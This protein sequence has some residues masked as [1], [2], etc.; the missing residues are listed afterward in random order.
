MEIS[1]LNTEFEPV[2]IVDVY[3]SIIWTKRYYKPGDFE[4]YIPAN[5]DILPYLK[6]DYYVKRDD[7]ETVMIIEKIEI[8]T[9]AENGDYFIITGR[10]LESILNRRIVWEQTNLNGNVVDQVYKVLENNIGSSALSYRKLAN[11][12]CKTPKLNVSDTIT[13]QATGDDLE[14]LLTEICTQYGL[15]W[16]IT[17]DEN[18]NFVFEMYKG[19]NSNAYFSPEFDNLITSDYSGDKSNYRNVAK[20][21]GEGEG[22]A[23]TS[24]VVGN[25]VGINRRELYVDA[26]DV[27]SNE[28][29]ITADDYKLLL[30]AR[31]KE[32]LQEQVFVKSFDGEVEP[33][34]TFKYREDYN[35]GDIVTVTNQYGITATPR[36]I[37]IIENWD[38]T[39]YKV[40]P[41][42]EEWEV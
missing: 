13:M 10:S 42:F 37:E 18:N 8:Q 33:S 41:T 39:G 29:K 22:T 26:R 9:D 12:I 40:V 19:N 28:G 15:G 35:L 4:L 38:D 32:K 20:V 30:N 6:Q 14:S 36:I 7:D 3:T 2:A 23:R 24:F 17:L 27:S 25:T 21:F 31:G 11:F 1:I 34:M 5:I 16:K